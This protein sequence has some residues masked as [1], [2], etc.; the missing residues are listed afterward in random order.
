[1]CVTSGISFFSSSFS[2]SF[3]GNRYEFNPRLLLE[4][5]GD[6][7]QEPVLL[8][9]PEQPAVGLHGRPSLCA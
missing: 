2:F 9:A 8:A 1:M 6:P 4:C 7:E 3:L 5:G